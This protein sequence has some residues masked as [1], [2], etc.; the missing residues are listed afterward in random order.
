MCLLRFID[1]YFFRK[2]VEAFLLNLK[3][4]FAFLFSLLCFQIYCFYIFKIFKFLIYRFHK[5]TYIF[6]SYFHCILFPIYNILWSR[7]NFRRS[8]NFIFS[9]VIDFTF[10]GHIWSRLLKICFIHSGMPRVN[11][12]FNHILFV[13]VQADG[14]LAVQ[15]F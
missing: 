13:L 3:E 11:L 12:S 1:L 14:I 6:Y 9:V 7:C 2:S 10:L 8:L 5:T 15:N 4:D